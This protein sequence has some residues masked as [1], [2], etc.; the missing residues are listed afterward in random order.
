MNC[1]TFEAANFQIPTTLAKNLFVDVIYFK[2]DIK[3]V[4]GGNKCDNF[5]Y[6]PN[7]HYL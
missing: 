4:L 7:K 5:S 2:T 1:A 6:P 3:Q